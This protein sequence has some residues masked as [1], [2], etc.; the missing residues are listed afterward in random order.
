MSRDRVQ[1]R[2]RTGRSLGRGRSG[3]AGGVPVAAAVGLVGVVL[4]MALLVGVA[5]LISSGDG[6]TAGAL[7]VPLGR[8]VVVVGLGYLIAVVLLI[9]AV[10]SPSVARAWVSA[11]AAAVIALGVSVYPLFATAA[12]AVDQ[13]QDIVPWIIA[14]IRG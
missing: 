8:I 3:G 1:L 5:T 11:L 13:A 7:I 4:G 6:L 9:L 12:S 14:L 10:R 2:R